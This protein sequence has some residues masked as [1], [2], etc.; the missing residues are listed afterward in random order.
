MKLHR[1]TFRIR[2]IL[3]A[4]IL[5]ATGLALVSGSIWHAFY[6]APK[7]SDIRRVDSRLPRA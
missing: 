6:N 5:A 1:A 3:V 7:S 4:M 2:A